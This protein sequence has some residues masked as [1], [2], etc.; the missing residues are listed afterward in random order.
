M[1]DHHRLQR[2][3]G[4][5][6]QGKLTAAV[7][8]FYKKPP[9]PNELR[10]LGLQPSD[11]PEQHVDVWEINWPAL[12]LF[13]QLQTQ[14]R[15]G[16]SGVIGLDYGVVFHELDRN[17][18]DDYDDMMWCIRHIEGHAAAILNRAN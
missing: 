16:P 10:A 4:G 9:D 12:R 11:F 7:S 15:C 17:K 13:M 18:P 6:P 3:I 8:E 1:G 5:G 2:G 14:W